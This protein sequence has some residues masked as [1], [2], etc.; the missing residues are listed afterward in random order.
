MGIFSKN[1]KQESFDNIASVVLIEQT[2]KY[3]NKTS[4]GL[5]FSNSAFGDPI[6]MSQTVPEMEQNLHSVS[7][8][9]TAGKRS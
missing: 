6:A 9:K 1:N 3:K 8:I 2:Q 5:S 7:L 4:W